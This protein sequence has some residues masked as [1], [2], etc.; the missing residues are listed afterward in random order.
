MRSLIEKGNGTPG[1]IRTCDPLIRSQILYPAELR[2]PNALSVLCRLARLQK[3]GLFLQFSEMSHDSFDLVRLEFI[4]ERG[5]TFVLDP[6][7]DIA[8]EFIV[9][10]RFHIS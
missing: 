8:K 2:V 3:C 6:V 9:R 10:F 7:R 5:H 1:K 4:F